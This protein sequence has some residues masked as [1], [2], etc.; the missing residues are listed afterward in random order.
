MDAAVAGATQA[1]QIVEHAR[2]PRAEAGRVLAQR[3]EQPIGQRVAPFRKIHPEQRE[4]EKGRRQ[5]VRL[6]SRQTSALPPRASCKTRHEID[7]GCLAC[8]SL[9]ELPERAL[10]EAVAEHAKREKRFEAVAA[11]AE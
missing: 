3:D 5:R 10:T 2:Q 8:S 9:R 6:E 4:I 11:K 7:L 1:F